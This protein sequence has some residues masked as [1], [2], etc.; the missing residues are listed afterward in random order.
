MSNHGLQ[1]VPISG[2]FLYIGVR[3]AS[4]TSRWPAVNKIVAQDEAYLSFENLSKIYVTRDGEEVHALTDI[5]LTQRRGEFLS[6]VGP[7][8]CGKSTLMMIAAGLV[9]PT[10]GTVR[11]RGR[12][13]F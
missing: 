1:P 10:S 13:T 7:S 9:R 2:R 4:G 3:P 5:S 8:G 12:S 11:V 6:H